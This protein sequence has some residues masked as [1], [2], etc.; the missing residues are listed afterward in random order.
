MHVV[1]ATLLL[2]EDARRYMTASQLADGR[3]PLD[4]Q[5]QMGH[6][7]LA[8]TNKYASLG[9]EQLK[10]PHDQHSTLRADKAKSEDVYGTVY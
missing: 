7:T 2:I 9:V 3:S 8:I 5:R 4:V 10:K 1:I 6:R